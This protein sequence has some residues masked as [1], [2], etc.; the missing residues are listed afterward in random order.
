MAIEALP[1]IIY[2]PEEVAIMV[3]KTPKVVRNWCEQKRLP[4]Y[5]IG[6]RWAI[7]AEALRQFAELAAGGSLAP[8]DITPG[9]MIG[10]VSV[11]E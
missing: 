1:R 2:W 6:R 8:T 10:P 7:P 4:A 5:K 3:G 9:S 11:A